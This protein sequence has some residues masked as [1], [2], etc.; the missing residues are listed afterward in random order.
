MGKRDFI[1]SYRKG[2]VLEA[3]LAFVIYKNLVDEFARFLVDF[4]KA[5]RP[6]E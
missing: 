6:R 5:P 1:G 2:D 4:V 3:C